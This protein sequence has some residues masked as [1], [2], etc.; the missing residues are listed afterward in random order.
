MFLSVA[1]EMKIESVRF[2]NSLKLFF[3]MLLPVAP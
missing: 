3:S 1:V 2:L